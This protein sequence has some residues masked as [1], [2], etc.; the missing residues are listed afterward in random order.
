VTRYEHSV[1][2]MLAVRRLGGNLEAQASALLHDVA[3]TVRRATL[4]VR[5]VRSDGDRR[6]CHMS[7]VRPRDA[8]THRP[9]TA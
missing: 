8:Q 1:G 2:A 3:H 5:C 4:R 9:S 6:P 7:Q